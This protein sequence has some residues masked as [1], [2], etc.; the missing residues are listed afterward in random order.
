MEDKYQVGKSYYLT[1]VTTRKIRLWQKLVVFSGHVKAAT[2]PDIWVNAW[3]NP[4]SGG[5]YATIDGTEIAVAPALSEFIHHLK[6]GI[7]T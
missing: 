6:K 1:A 7:E 3:R 4:L 2:S 5:S